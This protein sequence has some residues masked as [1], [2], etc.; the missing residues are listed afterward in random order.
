MNGL[1]FRIIGSQLVVLSTRMIIFYITLLLFAGYGIL[2]VYYWLSW[3]SIPEFFPNP[4]LHSTHAS[5]IIAARNEENNIGKLLQA[6]QKQTYPQNLFEVIVVNDHSTDNT[7]EVVEGF[8][9]VKRIDLETASSNSYKKKAIELGIRAASGSLILTTDADCIPP[10]MW[11]ETMVA[12]YEKEKPVFIAAPVVIQNNSSILQIFQALDFL[13]LQGITAAS[14]NKK[15]HSMCNGANLTYEKEV[16]NAIDGFENIDHIASGDDM[17]LMHK[18]TTKFPAKVRYLKSKQVI[19]STEPM[20]TWAAFFNQ[21]IRWAS[22]ARFYND[23]R[24]FW[25]LV[26][27]YLFNFSFLILLVAAFWNIKFLIF[28]L[29]LWVAK[30]IIELPLLYSITKYFDQSPLMKY[31]FFFQPLHIAYTIVAGWLGQFKKYEWK[32]RIVR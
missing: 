11:I 28:F 1:I 7:V 8:Q 17:L 5:V 2:I 12:F 14:V 25:A 16:F 19:V 22:K 18:I 30:T 10:T 29:L 15:I 20:K 3:K 21:R 13:V 26:L 9:N 32:G 27:V 23:K 24:I 4:L 6:L 31:F